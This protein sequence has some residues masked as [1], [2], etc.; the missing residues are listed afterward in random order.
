[1]VNN[2]TAITI[3]TIAK[4]KASRATN[5]L[6]SEPEMT[7]SNLIIHSTI[8]ILH[9]S[10]I[11]VTELPLINKTGMSVRRSTF[12]ATLPRN[13]RLNPRRPW[14]PTTI[15]SAFTSNAWAIIISATCS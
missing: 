7:K 12:S 13:N 5:Q 15:R 8:Y 10:N 3:S 14:L 6:A 4:F 1:M 9:F 2:K 11:Y